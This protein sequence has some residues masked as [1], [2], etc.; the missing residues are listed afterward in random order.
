[1]TFRMMF[2]SWIAKTS[3][4]QTVLFCGSYTL[5]RLEDKSIF[6]DIY[7][8]TVPIHITS[9]DNSVLVVKDPDAD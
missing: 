1:M 5:G 2:L 8:I 3:L 9:D 4:P 6:C 7:S